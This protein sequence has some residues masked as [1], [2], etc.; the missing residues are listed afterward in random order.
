[1]FFSPFFPLSLCCILG[2]LQLS[3]DAISFTLCSIV[4]GYGNHAIGELLDDCNMASFATNVTS[5]VTVGKV[6]LVYDED[7]DRDVAEFL[8]V[9]PSDISDGM[10]SEH[11]FHGLY[12][13][14][15]GR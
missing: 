10:C 13:A 8:N 11:G 12:L 7:F 3:I 9:F 2:Q 5:G 15:E 14:C 1:M 6:T 4:S